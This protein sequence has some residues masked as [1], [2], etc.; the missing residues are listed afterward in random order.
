MAGKWH[1][2]KN[3]YSLF[4]VVYSDMTLAICNLI[5]KEN[6]LAFLLLKS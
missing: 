4:M 6:K 2:F 3:S 5:K 1:Y